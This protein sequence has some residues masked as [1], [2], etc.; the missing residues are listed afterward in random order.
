MRQLFD[1]HMINLAKFDC[2]SQ[3]TFKSIDDYKRM[4][5][6][7][8]YKK[9]IAG[10]HVNFADTRKSMMTVGW[11]T[12]F[13]EHGKLVEGSTVTTNLEGEGTRKLQATAIVLGSFLSGQSTLIIKKDSRRS[14]SWLRF[15]DVS[16]SHGHPCVPRYRDWISS[17]LPSVGTYVSLWSPSA[18]GHGHWYFFVVHIRRLQ[19]A[20]SGEDESVACTHTCWTRHCEHHPVHS[21]YHEAY[22]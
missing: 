14:N 4:R 8:W 21:S 12:D 19:E 5:E 13:I 16:R 10:D 2:F 6:D 22:E 17:T 3:V 7:E 15:D 11:V 20:Q 18:T 9:Q 1:E